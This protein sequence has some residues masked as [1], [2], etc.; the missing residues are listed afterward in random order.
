M[1]NLFSLC[2]NYLKEEYGPDM[3]SHL[4]NKGKTKKKKDETAAIVVY[5][6]SI[7]SDK[8]RK[9]FLFSE[10]REMIKYIKQYCKVKMAQIIESIYHSKNVASLQIKAHEVYVKPLK[11]REALLTI[12]ENDDESEEESNIKELA[13]SFLIQHFVLEINQTTETHP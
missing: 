6:K 1:N 2:Q 8:S 13:N 12:K 10:Q 11:P 9:H 7:Y 5:A 3:A 4:S